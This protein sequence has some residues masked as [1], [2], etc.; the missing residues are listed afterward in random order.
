MQLNLGQLMD[1]TT[2]LRPETSLNSTSFTL[3]MVPLSMASSP[4]E[5]LSQTAEDS[6]SVV[7]MAP[8]L[9]CKR[10]RRL[11]PSVCW[12]LPCWILISA[13]DQFKSLH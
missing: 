12:F 13:T 7:T 11:P 2:Y 10:K 3:M 5:I 9:T 1:P 4:L 6:M 8:S